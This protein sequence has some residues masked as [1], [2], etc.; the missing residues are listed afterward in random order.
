MVSKSRTTKSTSTDT[1]PG[2]AFVL[3]QKQAEFKNSDKIY[4]GF[5]SGVGAGKTFVGAYDLLTRGIPG[6]LYAVVAPTYKVLSDATL[7]TFKDVAEKLDLWNE[8]AYRK[9]DNQVKLNNG[10][11]ILFRSGDQPGNL[12]GPTLAGCWMDECSQMKEEVFSVMIGRLRYGGRQGWLSG[13]FTPAGKDHWTYRVFGDATNP[14]VTLVQCSTKDNPFLETQ[15]Y[16]NLLLQYGK[17]EGGMLR[18]MQELEGQFVCVEGAEW[19]PECFTPDIWFDDWPVDDMAVKVVALDSSKG[20][21]GKTGD[22]S[23][24]AMVMYS[25]G[26]LWVEFDLN[27]QRNTTGMIDT[28]LE[29]QRSFRPHYF[30]IEAEFGGHVMG[31]DLMARSEQAKILVPAMLVPTQGIQKEVR[32]RRITP[33]LTRKLLRFRNTEM[34]KHGVQMMESFPHAEHDDS[35]DSLE[36][37][38]RLVNESIALAA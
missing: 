12:R 31:H 2:V 32:I 18:A 7:R 26:L 33:Y 5:V 13:T 17:G 6:A 37:A 4:R 11:E 25:N 9:T 20:L 23:S 28:A 1:P 29:I 21:G 14:N 22:Y 38:I 8:D 16:E 30:G 35:A 24:F 19:G 34:T 36:M 3:H 15:F 10:V 27:N